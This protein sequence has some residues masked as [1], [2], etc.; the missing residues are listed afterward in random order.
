M[1]HRR[2]SW[3]CLPGA[4]VGLAGCAPTGEEAGRAVL[5]V[6]PAALLV[7]LGLLR[8]LLRLWRRAEPDLVWRPGPALAAMAVLL[9]GA[10]LSLVGVPVEQPPS[11]P[12]GAYN[13]GVPGVLEWIDEAAYVFGPSLLAAILVSFRIWLTLSK[14]TAF[15]WAFGPAVVL[16]VGPAVPLALGLVPEPLVETA[17]SAW[18]F[19][20][21]YGIVPGAL[22]LGLVAEVLIR[23][24]TSRRA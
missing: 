10:V 9:A 24:R 4:L 17:I 19:S 22:L 5:F 20:G 7:G 23:T 13:D 6:A 3:S 12:Y 14:G 18:W 2:V 8:L 11:P 21:L 15:S 1:T 16:V